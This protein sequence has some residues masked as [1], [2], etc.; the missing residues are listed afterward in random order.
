MFVNFLISQ[1]MQIYFNKVLH[2]PYVLIE[3]YKCSSR[4]I[5][6]PFAYMLSKKALK[7]I[8]RE[9]DKINNF[10]TY[11][12]IRWI[13]YVNEFEFESNSIITALVKPLTFFIKKTT[14][15]W[16]PAIFLYLVVL[17]IIINLFKKN[18]TLFLF[19][20]I[21][22]HTM[23]MVLVSIS[24]EFRFQYPLIFFSHFAWVSLL[25]K[26]E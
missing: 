26:N 12:G 5:W 17:L 11:G 16:K 1:D 6:D 15:I 10:R 13:P 25:V 2:K 21:V 18:S 9:S 4:Y 14:F 7:T 24:P 22:L 23:G 20:P 19:V 3:Y 8:P